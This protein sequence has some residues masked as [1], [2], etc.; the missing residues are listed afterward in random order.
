M[1]AAVMI[2][3]CSKDNSLGDDPVSPQ[4]NIMGAYSGE[5]T[6]TGLADTGY[7]MID[8]DTRKYRGSSRDEGFPG[9][10]GGVYTYNGSSIVFD[11]T[12]YTGN[13]TVVLEGTY[14]IEKN[15]NDGLR[16]WRTSGAV[17]DEYRLRRLYR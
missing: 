2:T 3:A 15:S 11:D 10:C 12:C 7:L 9:I 17:T 14:N 5:F 16:I 4:N 6:R 8:L 13:R 1:A